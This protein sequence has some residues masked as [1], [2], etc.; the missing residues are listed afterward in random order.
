MTGQDPSII[1]LLRR[2]VPLPEEEAKEIIR[3][4]LINSGWSGETDDRADETALYN[5]ENVTDIKD[6][7]IKDRKPS[8]YT[9]SGTVLRVFRAH[10]KKLADIADFVEK[11]FRPEDYHMVKGSWTTG[12][13]GT[14][15]TAGITMF[16]KRKRILQ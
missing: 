9:S 13:A 8:S 15:G 16:I 11:N 2:R 10:S 4:R 14:A 12:K 5:E 7:D 6:L 3:S 1:L